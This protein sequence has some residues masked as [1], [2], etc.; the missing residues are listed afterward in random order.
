MLIK[1][2]YSFGAHVNVRTTDVRLIESFTFAAA[3]NFIYIS[4]ECYLAARSFAK[5]IFL[6]TW[7]KLVFYR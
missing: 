7:G 5:F 3:V 4:M 2:E 6:H 1:V